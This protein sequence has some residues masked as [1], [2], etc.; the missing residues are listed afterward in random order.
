MRKLL[1]VFNLTQSIRLKRVSVFRFLVITF[2]FTF[3]SGCKDEE[4]G[5]KLRFQTNEKTYSLNG[6]NLYGL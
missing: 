2:C 6:A 5:P 4:T 3:L 1:F